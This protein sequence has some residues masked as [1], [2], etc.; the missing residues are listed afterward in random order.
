VNVTFASLGQGASRFFRGESGA[1]AAGGG[2]GL[3]AAG[4]GVGGGAGF[5]SA[6]ATAG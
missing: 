5:G 3:L 2:A 4:G 1:L 6:L